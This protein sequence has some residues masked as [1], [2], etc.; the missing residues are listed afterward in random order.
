M[1]KPVVDIS[2][3]RFGKL[4]VV[5]RAGTNK[6]GS[7]LWNCKCDCG[8]ASVVESRTLRIGKAKSCGCS[9]G[10]KPKTDYGK[11]HGTRLYNIWRNMKSRCYNASRPDYINYG[12]RGIYVCDR[13]LEDFDTFASDVGAPVEG[14]TLDR[15]DNNGPYSPSNCRWA[16][17]SVQNSNQ[18][19][20]WR[21]GAG[22][23]NSWERRKAAGERCP[24]GN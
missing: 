1:G 17:K 11:R 10:K 13:W 7:A 15:I 14:M 12:G 23:P 21:K 18:R 3:M 19:H 20:E 9:Q 5:S 6:H 16:T 22:N 2:G 24:I 8:N 4:A